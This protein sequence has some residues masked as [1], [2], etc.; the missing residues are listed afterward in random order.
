MLNALSTS[1][2]AA[3]HQPHNTFLLV[4]EIVDEVNY[5]RLTENVQSM[6]TLCVGGTDKVRLIFS[7]DTPG[8]LSRK[9]FEGLDRNSKAT[10]LLLSS[11]GLS[12]GSCLAPSQSLA[13]SART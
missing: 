11:S 10:L 7:D 6:H 13:A 4:Q 2:G 5:N 1:P 9:I 8:S 12:P 3:V